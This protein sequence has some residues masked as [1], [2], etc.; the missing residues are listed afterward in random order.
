V[1]ACDRRND[2]MNVWSDYESDVQES[3]SVGVDQ[4][5]PAREEQA[6]PHKVGRY[7]AISGGLLWGLN[8]VVQELSI[9]S[10]GGPIEVL[11]MIGLFGTLISMVQVAVLERDDLAMFDTTS[12]CSTGVG[13]LLLLG[14]V[15]SLALIY[16]GGAYF[17]LVSE[18]ALY[19]QSL[20]M[21]D[22]F[23]VVFSVVAE[24]IVP[25]PLFIV[26]LVLIVGGV[27]L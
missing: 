16:L 13:I 18:S 8:N 12:T 17:L 21:S 20:L 19:N 11:G 27:V 15:V 1:G 14:Y 5:N 22:F 3:I 23:T 26:P 9:K 25:P 7:L 6:Y 24:H 4:G 10:Y 2:V